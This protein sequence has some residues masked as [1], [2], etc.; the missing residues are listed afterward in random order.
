[1]M[2][3]SSSLLDGLADDLAALFRSGNVTQ[4]DISKGTGISQS[5]IS[6]AR[7]RKL[8]RVT[9]DVVLL[10]DY[11]NILLSNDELP[12]SVCRAA[13]GFLSAGGSESEL[14]ET[15]DLSARP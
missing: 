1:M 14:V 9:K 10:R 5:T 2:Q 7:N 8:K 4:I 3:D 11:A 12:V 13:R 15:I 6:K